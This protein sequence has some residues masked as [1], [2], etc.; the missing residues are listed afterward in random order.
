MG[1]Y[2]SRGYYDHERKIHSEAYGTGVYDEDA[3]KILR[4]LAKHWGLKEPSIRWYSNWGSGSASSWKNELRLSHNPSMGLVIHEFAHLLH[5]KARGS[6]SLHSDNKHVKELSEALFRIQ[7]RGTSHHGLHF[8][9]VLNRVHVYAKSKGYWKP[10]L[11]K[12]QT[13]REEDIRKKKDEKAKEFVAKAYPHLREV[14]AEKIEKTKAEIEK[15]EA[16]K[17]RYAK[18]LQYYQK[19]YGTKT[20][21]ANRSIAALKRALSRYEAQSQENVEGM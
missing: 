12:W 14:V 10:Q 5:A 17:A 7:N 8:D 11:D 2:A 19:L 16:A 18:K 3:P 15:K 1:Q 9:V 21:K 13:K 6:S 20:K 4:K